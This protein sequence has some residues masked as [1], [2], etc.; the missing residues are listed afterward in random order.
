[1]SPSGLASSPSRRPSLRSGQAFSARFQL[2][3]TIPISPPRGD[4]AFLR[5]VPSSL[6]GVCYF[7]IEVSYLLREGHA[8]RREAPAR[9]TDFV[10]FQKSGQCLRKNVE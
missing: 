10:D 3:H 1:M 4:F 2:N 8:P 7:L 6:P 9:A 5:D